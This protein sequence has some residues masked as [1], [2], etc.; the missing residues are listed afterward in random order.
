M[1]YLTQSEIAANPSMHSR[2]AQCAATEGTDNPDLWVQENRRAW[3]AAPTW[4]TKW[5]S[6]RVT[7]PEEDYDPGADEGVITDNNIL[8]QVQGMLSR[9]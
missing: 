3:A 8:S 4:D 5:E 2:V 1:S 6:S 7:H 9:K